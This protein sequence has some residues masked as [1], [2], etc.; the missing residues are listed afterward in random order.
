MTVG[1][2]ASV[3]AVDI[4]GTSIKAA[5]AD[6]ATLS[7][8]RRIPVRGLS[9]EDVVAAAIDVAAELAEQAGPVVAVG[10]AVPGLVDEQAGVG[11]SSMFLGWRDVPFVELMRA[12]TGLP[13]AFSHDVSAGAYAESRAGAA[14][15]HRDWLF[16]AL[17]TGLG[18]TFVLDGRPYRGSAGL[19]GEL[20]HVVVRPGG[21]LCLCG[22]RGCLEMISAASAVSANYCARSGRNVDAAQVALLAGQGEAMAREVWL[23][24]IDALA[25]AVAGYVEAMNPSVVV[26]GGGLA[27]AGDALVTPLGEAVRARIAYAKPVPAVLR[28]RFVDESAL[29]GVALA[30]ADLAAVPGATFAPVFELPAAS[31]PIGRVRHSD[32][33]A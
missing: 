6:G 4:G 23:D 27:H 13:V 26:I 22:K 15:G 17:G 11:L 5:I 28:A 14:V 25:T 18:A 12:R 30:A 24:A 31:S 8:T 1:S 7:R 20:A 10:L 16:L 9:S 33:A 3:V 21:P 19:G 29:V 2:R 32:G